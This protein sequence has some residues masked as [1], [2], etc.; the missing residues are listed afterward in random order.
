M[1]SNWIAPAASAPKAF[2]VPCPFAIRAQCLWQKRGY[3]S[4]VPLR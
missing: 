2:G 4:F 1:N 3:G